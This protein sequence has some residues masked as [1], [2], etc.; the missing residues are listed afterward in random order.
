VK[1]LVG[2]LAGDR[3]LKGGSEEFFMKAE[4]ALKEKIRKH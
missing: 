1:V 4:A 2:A 3:W